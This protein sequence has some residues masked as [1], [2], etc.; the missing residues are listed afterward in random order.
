MNEATSPLNLLLLINSFLS[1]GLI[2]NQNES[3]R[4]DAT[5]QTQSS[6][7]NP[8]ETITWICLSLQLIL[9]LI[10]LKVTDS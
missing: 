10:K 4:D 6:V 2:L 8:L 9:L 3:K 7:S 1:V 5:S